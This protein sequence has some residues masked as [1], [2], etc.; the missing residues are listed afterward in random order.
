MWEMMG[1][2][3]WDDNKNEAVALR[4][5]YFSK[6]DNGREIDFYKDAYY[7][8]VSSAS[9]IICQIKPWNT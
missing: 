9:A 5:H 6:L 1:V 4:E 3:G 2:W 8:F 7:P